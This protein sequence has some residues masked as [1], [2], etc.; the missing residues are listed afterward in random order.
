MAL[1]DIH[2]TVPDGEVGNP[3][4]PAKG[5]QTWTPTG[6]GARRRADNPA[7]E[8]RE[9]SFRVDLLPAGVTTVEVAPTDATWVWLVHEHVEGTP[10]TW[11]AIAVP[12]VD[13][14]NF[15]DCPQVDTRTLGPMAAPPDPIWM[16]QLAALTDEIAAAQGHA[17]AAE[18]AAGRAAASAQSAANSVTAAS[19][20]ASTATAK[21]SEASA[22][23]TSAANSASSAGASATTATNAATGATAS[24]DAAALSESAAS[25][26]A[27][28]S[29]TQAGIATAKAGEAAA[30]ATAAAG[31]ATSAS[32]S[33]TTAA[34]KAA[35]AAA[36]AATVAGQVLTPDPAYPGLY[37]IGA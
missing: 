21:A 6:P 32:G 22:S 3:E 1:V 29:S 2:Q 37:R 14:V 31:S 12:D 30:S 9:A 7:R 26:S 23:A 10:P 24:A 35:E 33:A 18:L 15:R 8:V 20:S 27:S 36:L 25:G 34:T 11:R 17:E 13:R 16:Q 28:T 4:A 5:Y 19:G